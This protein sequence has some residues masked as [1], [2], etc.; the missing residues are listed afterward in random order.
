[1]KNKKLLAVFA[2]PDDE[3][4]GPGGTIAKYASEGVEVHLLVAT[5]G[6]EG[7]QGDRWLGEISDLGDWRA[8]ELRGAARVLG[9]KKVE[10]MGYHDGSLSEGILPELSNKIAKKI[11]EF[12]P[13]VILTFDQGGVSWHLD[14]I[15]IHKATSRAVKMVQEGKYFGNQFRVKKFYLHVMS[16]Q[17]IKTMRLPA[18]C[19]THEEITTRINIKDYWDKKE[20]ALKK[21]RTQ[22]KDWMRFL[23]RFRALPVM[24]EDYYLEITTLKD[25]KLPENDLFNGIE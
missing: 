16:K 21:H 23:R 11:L 13:D 10:F 6:E 9:I 25:L 15:A 3:S 1:M 17:M 19:I 5:K 8:H 20:A 2:H 18:Y 4:F 7:Q 14:H 24:E 12:L 22:R